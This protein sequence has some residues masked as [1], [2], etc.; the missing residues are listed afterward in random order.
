MELGK[1]SCMEVKRILEEIGRGM[2]LIAGR[3][4]KKPRKKLGK[5][6]RRYC[7]VTWKE[8]GE[9]YWKEQEG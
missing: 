1:G 6:I 8:L 7:K 4:Q 9:G 2:G 3:I 5:D